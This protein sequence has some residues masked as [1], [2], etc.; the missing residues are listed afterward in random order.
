[1]AFAIEIA[2]ESMGLDDPGTDTDSEPPAPRA[3]LD[4]R[5]YDG[6]VTIGRRQGP[7][8]VIPEHLSCYPAT[9]LIPPHGA[10]RSPTRASRLLPHAMT[11]KPCDQGGLRLGADDPIHQ[12]PL[13]EQKQGGNAVDA[14]AGRRVGVLINVELADHQRRAKCRRNT[15]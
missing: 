3:T 7:D 8:T 13:S 2:I 9:T 14:V 6:S 10:R 12:I 11:V 1:M 4:G 15:L 5:P